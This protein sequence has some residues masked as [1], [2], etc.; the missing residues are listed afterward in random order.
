MAGADHPRYWEHVIHGAAG[1]NVHLQR[2]VNP[3][4]GQAGALMSE[5]IPTSAGAVPAGGASAGRTPA[6]NAS[7]GN[8]SAGDA[9]AGDASA[10]D[11]SA[12]DA[13]AGHAS[14]GST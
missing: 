13:S 2:P 11:A 5:T 14:A 9:S 1:P 4:T 6:G 3:S 8:A 12:G 7:A 10:G